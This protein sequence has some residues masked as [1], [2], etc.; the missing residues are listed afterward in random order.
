MT[1][2]VRLIGGA[3]LWELVCKPG[4]IVGWQP[5]MGGNI[6]DFVAYASPSTF[7]RDTGG[8]YFHF[9]TNYARV[10]QDVSVIQQV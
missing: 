1:D 8:Y 3:R 4:G 2:Q 6:L 9:V 5:N 7:L 10:A